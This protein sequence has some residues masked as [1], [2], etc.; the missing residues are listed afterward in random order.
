MRML[1]GARFQRARFPKMHDL[2][3][4]Q[5]FFVVLWT[6]RVVDGE[7]VI[8][9]SQVGGVLSR[10]VDDVL[11]LVDTFRPKMGIRAR[12][13]RRTERVRPSLLRRIPLSP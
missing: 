4:F 11:L 9:K 1:G 13:F 8:V 10:I 12:V 7:M 6:R 5:V 2:Y 3:H